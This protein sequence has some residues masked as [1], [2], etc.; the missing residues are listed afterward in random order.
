MWPRW[1]LGWNDFDD[2]FSAMSQLRTYMDRV[3]DD[4]SSGRVW[5][6]RGLS[7]LGGWPRANLTDTGA[8]IS[9]SAEV[10]GLSEKDIKVSLNQDVLTLSGQRPIEAPKGYSTHR[11]ERPSV[12]FSRSFSLPCRVNPEHATASVKNGIL[13]VTLEKAADA[14]PRQISVK[15]A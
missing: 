9:V 2:M 6:G 12:E 7:G 3:M 8:S 1:N 14:M 5:E 4:S 13:T 15:A 10:P 11:Q